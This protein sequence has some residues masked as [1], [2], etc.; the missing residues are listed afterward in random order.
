MEHSRKVHPLTGLRTGMEISRHVPSLPGQGQVLGRG[1]VWS[2]P[3]MLPSSW[4][5]TG[6]MEA[7]RHVL[8]TLGGNW[9]GMGPGKTSSR[10]SSRDL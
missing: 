1:Q 10:L 6:G 2:L 8:F 7:S 9:P 4:A 3:S 5:G